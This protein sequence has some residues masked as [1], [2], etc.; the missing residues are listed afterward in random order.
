MQAAKAQSSLCE[1]SLAS[2]FA[3]FTNKEGLTVHSIL[4]QFNL[5][6]GLIH[7]HLVKGLFPLLIL[8][9]FSLY[10]TIVKP[11]KSKISQFTCTVNVLKFRKL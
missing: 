10:F 8:N 9:H 5:L 7:V 3:A 1:C 2:V 4:I 11:H 6:M